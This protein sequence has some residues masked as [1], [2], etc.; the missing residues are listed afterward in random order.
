MCECYVEVRHVPAGSFVKHALKLG[1]ISVSFHEEFGSI[2]KMPLF[3]NHLSKGKVTWFLW[4]D[5][6]QIVLIMRKMYQKC[7]LVHSDLSEYNILYYE[8]SLT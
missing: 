6:V 3:V 4:V 8:V 7:K 2:G 5:M 1:A